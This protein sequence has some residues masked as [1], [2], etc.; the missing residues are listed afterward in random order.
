MSDNFETW[1][2]TT[3]SQ[4]PPEELVKEVE[5]SVIPA[6]ETRIRYLETALALYGDMLMHGGAEINWSRINVDLKLSTPTSSI[7]DSMIPNLMALKGMIQTI[8]E[9]ETY[10]PGN[11][12]H[13]FKMTQMPLKMSFGS[14]PRDLEAMQFVVKDPWLKP[15]FSMEVNLYIDTHNYPVNVE[16][17]EMMRRILPLLE[18]DDE[19]RSQLTDAIDD[20]MSR[21]NQ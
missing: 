20:A 17:G 15:W 21:V 11:P 13:Q 16:L 14:L 19:Y 6:L 7:R 5:K 3:M 10:D 2:T 12:T 8:F 9:G 18:M 1:K 4:S